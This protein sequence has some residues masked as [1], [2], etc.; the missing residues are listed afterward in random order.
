ML[1]N[2]IPNLI[3]FGGVARV[4]YR[5]RLKM[6]YLSANESKQIASKCDMRTKLAK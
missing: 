6:K 2:F 5:Q 4:D 3:L 1:Q